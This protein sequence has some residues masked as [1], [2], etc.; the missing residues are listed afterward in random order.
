MNKPT[1]PENR[2]YK[3]P[4]MAAVFYTMA[5]CVAAMILL[6]WTLMRCFG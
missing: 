4:S 2:L 6:A 1:E 5:G 3:T